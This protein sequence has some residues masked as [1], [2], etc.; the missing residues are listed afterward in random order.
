[1]AIAASR[2]SETFDVSPFSANLALL[3]I[4]GRVKPAD[5]P[6][7]FPRTAAWLSQCYHRP[8]SSE[9]KLAA[10]DELLGTY[11][12]EPIRVPGA[13]ID[14]YHGDIVASYLNIGD[15][16][17]ITLLFD[18]ETSR[19]KLTSWGDWYEAFEA[20]NPELVEV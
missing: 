2:I 20:A 18:H 11:G 6:G 19:W 3:I 17:T 13:W 7:R 10:L 1:M 16:Y 15:T 4:R 12:V 5:H 9:I 8:S 14:R